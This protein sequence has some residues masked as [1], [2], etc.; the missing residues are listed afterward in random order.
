[1]LL[2]GA[3]LLL[4]T[5]LNFDLLVPAT[6][7]GLHKEK[8]SNL[9]GI[10]QWRVTLQKEF[11]SSLRHSRQLLCKTK[12]LT[13]HYLSDRLPGVQL[14]FVQQ[15]RLF[16]SVSLDL[17]TWLSLPDVKRLTYMTEML[18]FYR[19]LVQQL[20]DHEAIKE[21]S[22]FVSK[23][24]DLSFSLRDLSRHVSYQIS[25]WGL[26]SESQP[27]PTAKPLQIL[28]HQSRWR[29][30]QEVYLTLRSLESFLCRITRDFLLLRIKMAKETSLSMAPR[31]PL[32][33][34]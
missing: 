3:A 9:E 10:P 6:S 30:R 21:D 12:S 16:S 31:S 29:N 33:H 27:K 15:S 23:F 4:Q 25:L 13:R 24:Q 18:T 2:C 7:A 11:D 14:T 26:P 8:G 22:K 28:Q 19:G 32:L 5:L 34:F 17:R 20:S 1:M